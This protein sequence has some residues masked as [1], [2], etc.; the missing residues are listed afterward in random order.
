[1]KKKEDASKGIH[2]HH[3]H[4]RHSTLNHKALNQLPDFKLAFYESKIHITS[5]VVLVRDFLFKSKSRCGFL[6]Q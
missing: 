1:M 6:F 3:E 5:G 2:H 4:H